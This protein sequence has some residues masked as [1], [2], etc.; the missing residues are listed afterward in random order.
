MLILGRKYISIRILLLKAL[1]F[2]EKYLEFQEIRN[3]QKSR[4][5]IRGIQKKTPEQKRD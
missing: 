3:K 5:L 2:F 1:S 4:N